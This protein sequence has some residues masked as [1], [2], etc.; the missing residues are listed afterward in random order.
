MRRFASENDSAWVKI[1]SLNMANSSENS[2]DCSVIVSSLNFDKL[3]FVAVVVAHFG[4]RLNAAP[5][6]RS[7]NK[8]DQ[9]DRFGNKLHG[10]PWDGF[11]D[12]TFEAS[13]AAKGAV[14]V[15]GGA[16]AVMP[17]VPG[18]EQVQCRGVAYLADDDAVG[19]AAQAVFDSFLP[20]ETAIVVNIKCDVIRGDR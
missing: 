20:G 18:F 13:Q 6:G 7:S 19:P 2:G 12:E 4:D 1:H 16:P 11:L 17:G 9:V 5:A 8:H 3:V 15:N 10:C 14:C